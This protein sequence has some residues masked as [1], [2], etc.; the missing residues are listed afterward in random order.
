MPEYKSHTILEIA[1][2][3]KAFVSLRAGLTRG[4]V[5]DPERV[6]RQLQAQTRKLE[7]ARRRVQEQ[8]RRIE[9][10]GRRAEPKASNPGGAESG[11]ARTGAKGV[12]ERFHRLYYESSRDGGTWH[13]TFWLGVPVWKC[14]LD[15]WVYQEM[16]FEQKPDL[17]VETGTAFGGS[18]LYMASLCDV[19]DHG[20][21]ITVDIQPRDNRP[22]HE[23]ITYL[24]GSSTDGTIVD[25]VKRAANG[26]KTLV[27]LDS[28]HSKDHVLDELKTYNGMV[29]N[30][31]YM[32]VEDTNVNGHPV[33]PRFGPGPMEAVDEFLQTNKDFAVDE[34]KE[35]FFMTFNPR[36]YLKKTER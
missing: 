24:N 19:L 21:I 22:S 29:H 9:Q 27:I 31:G 30:G 32:I 4:P 18:A 28:D 15:L 10:P 13:D 23:R 1:R 3:I 11:G 2:G 35:K 16:I 34:S 36:G 26:G 6:E 7:Q 8:E 12:V 5:P 14:P 33:K 17:I 25:E 20:R